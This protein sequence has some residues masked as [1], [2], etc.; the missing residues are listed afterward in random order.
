LPYRK[1]PFSGNSYYHVYNR[2]VEKRDIFLEKRDYEAF[3]D[4]L[5]FYIRPREKDKTRP[6][7][8]RKEY[9][10]RLGMFEK[11]IKVIS[12]VLMPNHL[13]F[14]FYQAEKDNITQLMRR[15][16]TAYSMY[17]NR[18]YDRVGSLCQGRFKAK[19][20]ESEKYLLH[21]TRYHHRNPQDLVTRTGLVSYPWSSYREYL[22]LRRD[23]LSQPE[24]VLAYF[25]KTKKNLSYQSFVEKLEVDEKIIES[26]LFDKQ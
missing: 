22:G 26:C 7:L 24:L 5:H 21:L 2:G 15:I 1:T 12:Y 19:L 9:L 13:H 6:V 17:F 10:P 4:I 3:L 23:K 8:A 18:K 25:S 16:G 14:L 11:K 20:I